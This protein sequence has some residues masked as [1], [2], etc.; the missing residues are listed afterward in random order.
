MILITTNVKDLEIAMRMDSVEEMPIDHTRW[1]FPG[2]EELV[3]S[4]NKNDVLATYEFFKITIGKTDNPIY[5]TKNKIELRQELQKQFGINVLNTPDIRIGEQL[6]L[7][8]YSD[9]TG[10]PINILKKCGGSPRE[11]INVKDCIPHWANFET[12]EFQELKNYFENV[13]ILNGN[14]KGSLSKSV[15]FHGIK[16]DYGSGG[17]HSSIEP[18][19]YEEDD[20]WMILDE[21]IGL[22]RP[23]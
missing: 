19:I 4:Y 5:A 9:V 1:C 2:D 16:I 21:D 17:A 13:T 3:L 12:K 23:N 20:Y 18:G 11:I 10:V 6:M 7:K 14:L 15:I 8:L 22:K